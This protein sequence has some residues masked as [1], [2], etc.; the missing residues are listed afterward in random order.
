M[1]SS[2]WYQ[3]LIRLRCRK[4]ASTW[5]RMYPACSGHS[6]LK[7]INHEN[8]N[9]ESEFSWQ[10]SAVVMFNQ[11]NRLFPGHPHGPLQVHLS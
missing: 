9:L 2:W 3:S 8:S 5:A 11:Y 10:K 6:F 1:I 4:I 7:K